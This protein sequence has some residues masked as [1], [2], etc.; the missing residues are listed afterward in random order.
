MDSV[1]RERERLQNI[2][3]L[4]QEIKDF[5]EGRLGTIFIDYKAFEMDP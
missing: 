5:S 3:G 4:F 1:L 2:R